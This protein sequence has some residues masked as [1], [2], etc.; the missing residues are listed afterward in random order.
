MLRSITGIGPVA[1]LTLLATLPELG[2]LSHKQLATLVRLA[3]SARDSG[4]L[5]GKRT[6]W[7]DR[8]RTREGLYM[9]ALCA[10]RHNPVIHTFYERLVAKGKPHKVLLTAC[11]SSS[12]SA[13]PCFAPRPPG[14]PP[15]PLDVPT[16]LLLGL[17]TSPI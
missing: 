15:M 14:I 13:M 12:P 7:G 9:P 6:I 5:R 16:Q 4:T 17:A 3:A 10:V 11:I 2:T 1:S 8:A